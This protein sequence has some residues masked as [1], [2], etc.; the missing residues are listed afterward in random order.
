MAAFG[1]A[2]LGFNCKVGVAVFGVKL[3][4]GGCSQGKRGWGC[5]SR[6]RMRVAGLV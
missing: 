3:S 6:D 4:W 5:F 2:A 1:V